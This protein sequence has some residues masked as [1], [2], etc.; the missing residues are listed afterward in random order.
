MENLNINK[1]DYV[2]KVDA[3]SGKRFVRI[4]KSLGDVANEEVMV[5]GP[6]R[7]F[8]G[9]VEQAVVLGAWIGLDEDGFLAFMKEKYEKYITELNKD[10]RP[11]TTFQLIKGG[12]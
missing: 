9:V 12:R 3:L 8:D 10:C 2:L 7:I 6:I 5:N 11:K 1:N 4:P